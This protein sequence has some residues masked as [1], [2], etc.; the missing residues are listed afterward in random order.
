MIRSAGETGGGVVNHAEE[1]LQHIR[2]EKANVKLNGQ[3]RSSTLQYIAGQ[4]GNRRLHSTH[5]GCHINWNDQYLE[6]LSTPLL[7]LDEI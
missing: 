4:G 2:R 5:C 7:D 6:V 1:M 3:A